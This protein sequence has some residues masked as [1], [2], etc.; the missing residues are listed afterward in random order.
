MKIV[1]G[2][3]FAIVLI[4]VCSVIISPTL[5]FVGGAGKIK[6]YQYPVTKVELEKA[7][8]AVLKNGTN[9]H[10][11]TNLYFYSS[12]DSINKVTTESSDSTKGSVRVTQYYND[13]VNYLTVYISANGFRYEYILGY[14]GDSTYW[15]E[16]QNSEIAIIYA[17]DEKNNGGYE[18]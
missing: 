6:G 13:G 18:K 16:S 8:Q 7:I 9:V 14:Y 2:L 5:H 11:D 17:Y 3:I 1:A 15:K 4:L 12:Y 10:R